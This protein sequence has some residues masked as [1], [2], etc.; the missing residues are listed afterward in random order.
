MDAVRSWASVFPPWSRTS[1]ITELGA[2]PAPLA[3][4]A[5]ENATTQDV[6]AGS[7]VAW[8]DRVL[9]AAERKAA[10]SR[11]AE[12]AA[13]KR[14][15]AANEAEAT[16]ATKCASLE[17]DLDALRGQ[18]ERGQAALMGDAIRDGS[19]LSEWVPMTCDF[20]AL[21]QFLVVTV[22]KKNTRPA[23]PVVHESGVVCEDGVHV[24]IPCSNIHADC[25]RPW[26]AVGFGLPSAG[27]QS[28]Q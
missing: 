8:S 26:H 7:L 6:I 14:A 28:F 21:P 23:I 9:D 15:E 20:I 11:E 24:K 12:L 16:A 22:Q 5:T 17:A 13:E 3:R 4:K 18:A 1:A 2:T 19:V 25:E 27:R 10:A